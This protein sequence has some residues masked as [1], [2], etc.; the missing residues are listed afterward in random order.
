MLRQ[1]SMTARTGSSWGRNTLLVLAALSPHKAITDTTY[2]LG[3][4][5]LLSLTA[6]TQAGLTN[7]TFLLSEAAVRR[8]FNTVVV[9]VLV[10]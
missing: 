4:I 5:H 2:L 9:L 3:R 8:L 10:V 1:K 7:S 6:G